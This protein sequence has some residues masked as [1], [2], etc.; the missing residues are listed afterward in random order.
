[1]K[2]G[3]KAQMMKIALKIGDIMFS[4]YWLKELGSILVDLQAWRMILHEKENEIVYHKNIINMEPLLSKEF[5][6]LCW[7]LV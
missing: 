6:S 7:N 4:D 2:E 1:M 3:V 5:H